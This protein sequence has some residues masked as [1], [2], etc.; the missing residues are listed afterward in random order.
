MHILVDELGVLLS[1]DV[2][3][4]NHQHVSQLETVLAARLNSIDTIETAQIKIQ[5]NL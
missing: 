3:G 5:P 4:V 1:L 2:T